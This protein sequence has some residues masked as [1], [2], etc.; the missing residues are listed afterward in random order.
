MWGLHSLWALALGVVVMWA[1]ARNYAWLRVTIFH[2]AFLWVASLFVPA[3][4]DRP[5]RRDEV[6]RPAPARHQLLHEELLPAAAVLPAADLL[7]LGLRLVGEPGLRRA[8]GGVGV[9]L[10]V[11]RLLRSA[12]VGPA[13]ADRGVLRLQ[14]VRLHQRDAARPVEHQQQRRASGERPAGGRRVRD[15]PVRRRRTGAARHPRPDRDRGDRADPARGAGPTP[16][17]AGAPA[18]AADGVR[19]RDRPAPRSR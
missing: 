17:P 1:G 18:R 5:G 15:D 19:H 6:A 3:L 13:R 11:R 16:D 12:P 4:V 7:R 8:A 9:H 2:L 10:D 14:P